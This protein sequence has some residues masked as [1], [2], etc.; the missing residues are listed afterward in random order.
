MAMPNDFSSIVSDIYQSMVEKGYTGT[1]ADLAV[2][3]SALSD[4]NGATTKWIDLGASSAYAIAVEHGYTGTEEEWIALLMNI[5]QNAQI[6]KHSADSAA[7]SAASAKQSEEAIP[8]KKEEALQAIASA[9]S[10]A[11]QSVNTAGTT[12]TGNVNSA[13]QT[14]VQAVNAAGT[15]QIGLVQQEGSD[16]KDIVIAE[17]EKQTQRVSSQGILEVQAVA[18]EGTRQTGLVTSEGD[19]QVARVTAEGTTQVG[20][21]TAEG[22]TQVGNVSAEGT[23]QIT[24]VQ[25]KG[26]EVIDSI[27]ADYS[28]LTQNV[29]DL[30]SAVDEVS[31]TLGTVVDAKEGTIATANEWGTVPYVIKSG[32]TYSIRNLSSEATMTVRTRATID[33]S[34]VDSPSAVG[35]NSTV[36]F[37]A[38]GDANYLRL[39]S[40]KSSTP[41]KIE[42]LGTD[43]MLIKSE[44]ERLENDKLNV[45]AYEHKTTGTCTAANTFQNFPFKMKQGKTYICSALG[46]GNTMSFRT[47]LTE[48]GGNIDSLNAVAYGSPKS[49]TATG[50]A[51]YIRVNSYLANGAFSIEEAETIAY[52]I[53]QLQPKVPI[54]NLPSAIYAV[55]GKELN[56]YFDNI[57]ENSEKYSFDVVCTKGTQMERGFQFTPVDDDAGTYTLTINAYLDNEIIA[58]AETSLIVSAEDANS[59]ESVS[60]ILMGDSTVNGTDTQIVAN[61]ADDTMTV[62]S[63][64]T[65]GASPALHEGRTGW[66]FQYY[67]NSAEIGG[68]TNPFRNPTSG[69]FDAS[70]YFTSTG[71]SAPD[72]FFIQLGINDMFLKNDD[73]AVYSQTKTCL[74]QCNAMITSLKSAAPNIKIGIVVTIPPNRSQ[75]AFGKAYGCGQTRERYKRNNMLFV[76]SIIDAYDERESDSIYLVPIFTNLDTTYNMGLESTPVNARNTITYE[77]PIANGSVHPVE[78]GYKQLADVYMAFIKAIG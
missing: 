42:R 11:L 69:V 58:T 21:V 57:C 32:K 67:Y 48:D 52:E 68:I 36:T 47:R 23:A 3:L 12:Q 6:A 73:D 10:D 43:L 46:A 38:S 2:A 14:Q 35:P 78:S 33:G 29:S 55:T 30:K 40:T 44:E 64:G 17:G 66:T 49:F 45:V 77:S 76:K 75:D 41:W 62:T 54:L 59:G 53:E 24:A 60:F 37:T 72:W 31:N 1:E 22:T 74:T 16:Q 5:T 61:F 18:D 13:G 71:I 34:S 26:A 8:T 27:P 15:T 70:Y 28:A 7:E 9:E 63:K 25:D 20:L 51:N 50:N 39:I 4:D 19:T 65:R 56:I